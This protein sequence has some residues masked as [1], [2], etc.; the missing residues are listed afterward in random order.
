MSIEFFCESLERNINERLVDASKPLLDN[1]CST[2]E[3]FKLLSGYRKGLI[4]SIEIAKKTYKDIYETE[5]NLK[6]GVNNE[7]S[8]STK[9]KEKRFY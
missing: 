6:S 8:N 4:E 9:G 7:S 1:G 2:I 3:H 5:V